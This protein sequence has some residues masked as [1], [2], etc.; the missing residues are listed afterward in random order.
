[1]FFSR[2]IP[3]LLLSPLL[4]SAEDVALEEILEASREIRKEAS[5]QPEEVPVPLEVPDTVLST[6]TAWLK[7]RELPPDPS[8]NS[9][10][11]TQQQRAWNTI[12]SGT[13]E[14]SAVANLGDGPP[15]PPVPEDIMYVYFSLSMPD[16]TI[17]ALFHQALAHDELRSIVFVLRGWKPPGL[18]DLVARLNKLFP[19]AKKL[20]DLPNV[21]IDPNLYEQQGVDRVPTFS[22]KDRNGRWEQ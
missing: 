14:G 19:G 17:K 22:T 10:S 4:V 11:K 13:E 1:M 20:Q 3:L 12:M 9:E 16:E 18:N 7:G 21:Q 2:F 6:D 15:R 5:E 8:G